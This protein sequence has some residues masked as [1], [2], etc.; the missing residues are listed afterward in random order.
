MI[1]L[2]ILLVAL[3][4]PSQQTPATITVAWADDRTALTVIWSAPAPV[5]LYAHEPGSAVWVGLQNGQPCD[6]TG[7]T[8]L[9]P[10]GVDQGYAAKPGRT[11]VLL[12]TDGQTVLAQTAIPARY[13]VTLP[14]IAR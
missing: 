9:Y 11:L 5:C 1:R 12:A 10:G 13:T 3:L 4:I 2:L 8:V 14:I 7:Q 6:T